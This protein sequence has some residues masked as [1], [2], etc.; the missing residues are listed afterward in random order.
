MEESEFISKK[1]V[2]YYYSY[3][4]M[5]TKKLLEGIVKDFSNITLIPVTPEVQIDLENYDYIGFASGIYYMNFGKPIY[6]LLKRTENLQGKPCFIL[7]TSGGLKER[8]KYCIK[9]LIE[10]QGGKF[11]DGFN[12][13][14]F[15]C[16]FPINL[17]GGMNKGKPDEEDI[18]NAQDFLKATIK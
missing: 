7:S 1:I 12:C 6:D 4:T 10:K 16:I 13:L 17:F 3:H 14:G 11:L 18:K 9:D 15:D 2:I 5:S 8:Y